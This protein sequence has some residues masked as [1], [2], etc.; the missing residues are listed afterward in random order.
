MTE[1]GDSVKKIRFTTGAERTSQTDAWTACRS[2]YVGRSQ[3]AFLRR[4]SEYRGRAIYCLKSGSCTC[5]TQRMRP[6]VQRQLVPLHS[7]FDRLNVPRLKLG[8]VGT[9]NQ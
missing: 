9:I 8:Q 5:L 6:S 4:G 1:V 3:P 7:D 2:S